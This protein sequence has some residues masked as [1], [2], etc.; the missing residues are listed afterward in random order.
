MLTT[1][2]MGYFFCL[3]L[4]GEDMNSWKSIRGI[5]SDNI[6]IQQASAKFLVWQISPFLRVCPLESP[7][8]ENVEKMHQ[9]L[10]GNVLEYCDFSHSYK[11]EAQF[12]IFHK[13]TGSY[14]TI[15]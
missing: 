15:S 11:F 10:D 13:H 5:N 1:I 14:L 2:V 12:H 6:E 9:H 3:Y 4:E 8:L 7:I